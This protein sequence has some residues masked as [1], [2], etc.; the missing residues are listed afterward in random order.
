MTVYVVTWEEDYEGGS[1]VGVFATEEAANEYVRVT[2]RPS[3]YHSGS[4][5]VTDI[6][7]R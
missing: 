5:T 2:G 1:V 6:R 7:P 3:K 4:Y